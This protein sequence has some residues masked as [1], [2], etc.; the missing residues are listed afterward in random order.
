MSFRGGAGGAG[1]MADPLVVALGS[2][3][4]ADR[5]FPQSVLQRPPLTHGSAR[6]PAHSQGGKGDNNNTTTKYIFIISPKTTTQERRGRE[7]GSVRERPSKR[8]KEKEQ[9]RE[10]DRE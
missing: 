10:R 6:R 2:L 3:R 9:Q 1:L 4:K 7:R 5:L 8:E